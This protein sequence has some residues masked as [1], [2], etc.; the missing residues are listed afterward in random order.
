MEVSS[1]TSHNRIE[2]RFEKHNCYDSA[3]LQLFIASFS[4]SIPASAD[5]HRSECSKVFQ[6][7]VIFIS[8]LL[9]WIDVSAGHILVEEIAGQSISFSKGRIAKY[10]VNICEGADTLSSRPYL[11]S[12][13][14]LYSCS[15][16]SPHLEDFLLENLCFFNK[17]SSSFCHSLRIARREWSPMAIMLFWL[18]GSSTFTTYLLFLIRL[19]WKPRTAETFLLHSGSSLLTKKVFVTVVHN[20]S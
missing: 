12:E 8:F 4:P 15:V 9:A 3:P 13:T 1:Y 17:S 5:S 2:W 19:C 14:I 10:F 16:S 20:L 7:I 18:T 6:L 11:E